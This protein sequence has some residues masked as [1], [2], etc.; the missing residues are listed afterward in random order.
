MDMNPAERSFAWITLSAL[1]AIALVAAVSRPALAAEPS[2]A[3]G[4]TVSKSAVP[5]N[6]AFDNR[7]R[8]FL[9]KRF[10]LPDPKDVQLGPV[11]RT[12]MPGVF[13]RQ[14]TLSNDRG[15][16]AKAQVFSDAAGKQ[17]IVGTLFDLTKDPWQHV[18]LGRIHL[19]D[20]PV[21]GS[22]NAPVTIVEFAD[23]ECPY[24]AHAFSVLETMVHT[25]YKGKIRVLFKNFPLN[26]HPWAVRA[27]LA[28]DCARL[29]NPKDFWSF[30]R[31]FYTNQ[32][33]ITPQNLDSRVDQTAKRLGL[34]TGLLNACMNNRASLERV[35]Q[36]QTDGRALGVTST[37]TFFINGVKVVGLPDEKAF[38]FVVKSQVEE[39]T[40][41]ARK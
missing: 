11:T 40:K 38:N 39:A 30:A 12:T 37:P 33:F 15:Q 25:T 29:Q 14:I 27:A 24:C 20:R 7:L 8:E 36:D 34:D 13:E 2:N 17:V 16:S 23:F 4:S 35:V 28:A 5:S 1:A 32:G 21:M 6:P 3:S 19:A 22:P 41:S 31:E 9:Q 26:S 10:L 18:D